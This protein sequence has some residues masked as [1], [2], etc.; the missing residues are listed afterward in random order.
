MGTSKLTVAD[1]K[2]LAALLG[3]SEQYLYQ[4]LR[5][6]RDMN[7][8]EARRCED[9]SKGELMRWDL[10]Q[11]S[12]RGIWPELT[13]RRD[14]PVENALSSD[15]AVESSAAPPSVTEPAH[16]PGVNDRRH[17][18]REITRRKAERRGPDRRVGDRSKRTGPTEGGEG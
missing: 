1:R 7:P 15:Q 11:K 3:L 8:T 4:C 10:C 14:A 9:E 18:R 5:G 6:L 16:A 13:R 12:W 17:D 2:R